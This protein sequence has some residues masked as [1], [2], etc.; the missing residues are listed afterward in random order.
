MHF[1]KSMLSLSSPEVKNKS[2]RAVGRKA[3]FRD[4]SMERVLRSAGCTLHLYAD[5]TRY[6]SS[7][8]THSLAWALHGKQPAQDDKNNKLAGNQLDT[9]L[10][11]T[12]ARQSIGLPVGP[13]SSLILAEIIGTSID[14]TI[15]KA[16]VTQ[17]LRYTARR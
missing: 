4:V 17:G 6:Y 13:D 2:E 5:F 1:L 8:Y 14:E 16:G 12:Q 11:A 9:F 15:Q 3:Y 10:R 7:I